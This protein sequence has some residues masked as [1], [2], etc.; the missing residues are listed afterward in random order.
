MT[1]DQATQILEDCAGDACPGEKTSE[2]RMGAGRTIKVCV[3]CWN[4]HAY[5]RRAARKEQLAA[6]PKDC[7]RCAARPHTWTYAGHRLCGRC[8]TKTAREQ[9]ASTAKLGDLAILAGLSGARLFT[10]DDW[11]G[12]P[13]QEDGHAKA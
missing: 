5:A 7:A 2:V 3:D 10:T 13:A 1:Y 8:K 11:K 6:R 4:R 12:L 9:A